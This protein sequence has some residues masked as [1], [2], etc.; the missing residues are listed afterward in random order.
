MPAQTLRP[1]QSDAV[2]RACQF[3]EENLDSNEPG[4]TKLFT[5]PTG[6]G[7]GTCQL[8]ILKTLRMMGIDAWILTPSIEIERGFLERLDI[9][10]DCSS[11]TIA[12]RAWDVGISTGERF[13][14]RLLKGEIDCPEAL[15]IDEPQEFIGSN[16]TPETIM[17]IVGGIPLVGF[18]ATPYRASPKGTKEFREL[19]GEP[20][21]MLGFTEAKNEGWISM[22]TFSVHPL[23][24]DDAVKLAGSEFSGRSVSHAYSSRIADLARLVESYWAGRFEVPTMVSV[25]SVSVGE[26]LSIALKVLKVNPFFV[27]AKTPGAERVTAYRA[28]QRGEA[29]LLQISVLTR[30]A[31][32]PGMRRL[33]DAQP[34]F[35]GVRWMQTIG[36]VM[37]PGP[38]PSEVIVTNRNLER[39]AYLL[40]GFVPTGAVIESQVA[41]GGASKRT[42]ARE[43]GLE[44]LS[45]FKRIPV[46]LAGGGEATTFNVYSV[47]KEGICRDFFAFLLPGKD[48]PVWATRKR[49]PTGDALHYWDYERW[50]LCEAPPSD[51]TGFATSSAR[52]LSD[53]QRNWWHKAAGRYGL[54]RS[55]AEK[56]SQRQFQALP[57]LKDLGV[58]ISV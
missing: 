23:C 12:K 49:V 8:A 6:T 28:A 30:G 19:W 42:G 33:I 37:R 44:A 54:E 39:H 14:N 26:A 41:F 3:I 25:P 24:D 11:A 51:L 36:R 46:P 57:V 2:A 48:T 50:S 9:S 10:T 56:L 1:Y 43:L 31:D 32:L 52:P 20:E 7:K 55:A 58:K 22:P 47:G 34:T 17:A 18:T 16:T 15:V 13:V 4:C 27:H 21:V 53:K 35:S 29:A 5:A 38:V 45:R 40:S